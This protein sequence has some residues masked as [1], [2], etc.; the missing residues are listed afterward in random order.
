M[1]CLTCLKLIALEGGKFGCFDKKCPHNRFSYI[2][3]AD[4]LMEV[5]S[6]C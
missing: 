3:L 2:K 4:N 5:V 1:N 6:H